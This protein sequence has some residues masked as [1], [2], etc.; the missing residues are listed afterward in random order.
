MGLL[1]DFP[2]Y[3]PAGENLANA[4]S[5]LPSPENLDI[6][7]PS[8]R[9]AQLIPEN[10]VLNDL[11]WRD[12]EFVKYIHNKFLNNPEIFT[13]PNWEL[14]NYEIVSI[15]C[16]AWIG[17]SFIDIVNKISPEDEAWLQTLYPYKTGKKNIVFGD[18]VI[19]HYSYYAQQEVLRNTDILERYRLFANN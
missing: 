11:Y 4:I 15:H 13:I 19:S 1:T 2:Q 5:K 18:C 12:P 6:F 14:S 8:L 3:S 10:T 7:N 17:S 16:I 9:I